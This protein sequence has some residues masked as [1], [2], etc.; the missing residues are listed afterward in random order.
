M[1][2]GGK[3][4]WDADYDDGVPA[5]YDI[6]DYSTVDDGIADWST[7]GGDGISTIGPPSHDNDGGRGRRQQLPSAPPALGDDD[8]EHAG[9]SP[10]MDSR[11]RRE[12]APSV[13]NDDAD[14]SY[15]MYATPDDF[16]DIDT[17]TNLDYDWKGA[18]GRTTSTDCSSDD[19]VY[20]ARLDHPYTSENDLP[21]GITLRDQQEDAMMRLLA[22]QLRRDWASSQCSNSA[23]ERRIRDFKFAQQ[24]RREKYGN[25]RP[26]GI[27]GLYDH[28]AAIRLDLEWAED[29]AWR[30]VNKEPYLSWTDFEESRDKGINRPFFTYFILLFCTVMLIVSIGVNGWDIEPLS[31][32]PMVGP[33]AETL[34]K[35]GA[36]QTSLIVNEGE[37]FRLFSPMVLHAGVIHYALNMLA[38]WFIGGA[39]EKSH[40]FFAAAILF[41]IPATGGTILSAIF[42]PEYISVGASGGIFGLIGSCIADIGMNWSLLFSK[43]V[44]HHDEGVR[45]RH[46]K[47]LLWL[48]FDIVLNILIGLTP[49]VDN[50]THLG[51]MIYG[52]LCGLSTMER[53]SL[54][55][56]GVKTD[57]CS[58]ARIVVVKFAGLIL[59]VVFIVVTTVLLIHSDGQS[60]PCSN[61]RYV[62]CVPFPPWAAQDDKWWYCDDCPTVVADAQKD[63]ETGYFEVLKLTCPDGE[64]EDIDL[65]GQQ[66]SDREWLRKQLP[67][68]C[69]DFCDDI[70]KN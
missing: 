25:E 44:N 57:F 35:L 9:M 24:K 39:V 2:N 26:W 64:V 30:R 36:K 1:T 69:R 20:A 23:L 29:A 60:S 16:T 40:G 10:R 33:S 66:I 8:D 50:F 43:Q 3:T 67:S 63:D 6:T 17:A 4:K 68:Y 31:V 5:D 70:F 32:N 45:F 14:D 34:L 21:P 7:V 52:F 55:F 48:I 61:C 53:L 65:S 47:V 27:L 13:S 28:L 62:S 41:T 46:T 58:R 12:E 38:L 49:F 18:G 54:D 15:A 59:S 19:V 37:W 11:S 22:G 56:F 51:G 42:L